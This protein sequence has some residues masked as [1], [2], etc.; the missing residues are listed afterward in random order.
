MNGMQ[1]DS[2]ERGAWSVLSVT[3]EVDLAT[4]PELQNALDTA[5][6]GSTEVVIDLS[7]VTFLDSTGLGVLVRAHRRAG[8]QGARL[9]LV[10]TESTVRRVID[11][12]GLAGVFSLYDSLETAIR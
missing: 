9:R 12:T 4:S 5:L 8:E 2:A 10:V 11:V 1:I 3:G 7:Q 6:E